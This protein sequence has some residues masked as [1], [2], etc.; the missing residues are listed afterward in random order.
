[1][2]EIWNNIMEYKWIV[3][4]GIAAFVF[5]IVATIRKFKPLMDVAKENKRMEEQYS[6]L[7]VQKLENLDDDTLVKAI[8]YNMW[9]KMADDMSDEFDIVDKQNDYKKAV[10]TV[11]KL[12]EDFNDGGFEQIYLTASAKFGRISAMA[13]ESINA[14]LSAKAMAAAYEIYFDN[15][16]VFDN[17]TRLGENDAYLFDE[18]EQQMQAARESEDVKML[19]AKYIRSNLEEICK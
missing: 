19:C 2:Q 10:Y 8:M 18:V 15:R 7:T 5:F 12:N 14:P 6:Q 16:A 13:Y 17:A 4:A 9:S 1:M 3:L 11:I